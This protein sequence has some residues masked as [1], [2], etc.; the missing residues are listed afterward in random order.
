MRP[1][2]T[3]GRSRS[4][5]AIREAR[6][7]TG[8]LG[9]V[10]APQIRITLYRVRGGTLE[11]VWSDVKRVDADATGYLDLLVPFKGLGTFRLEVTRGSE[12]LA[13]GIANLGPKCKSDCSGG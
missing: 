12:L 5:H 1:G 4:S 9:P 13:W 2:L 8:G 10:G 6:L 7:E 3:T 11:I